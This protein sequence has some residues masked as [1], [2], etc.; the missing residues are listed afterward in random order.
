MREWGFQSG[1]GSGVRTM[2][3]FWSGTRPRNHRNAI[4]T[5]KLDRTPLSASGCCSTPLHY[6][7]AGQFFFPPSSPNPR[8]AFVQLTSHNLSRH[9]PPSASASY[10]IPHPTALKSVFSFISRLG[11][12]RIPS[13]FFSL[14]SLFFLLAS[15]LLAWL[16]FGRTHIHTPWA[17][18]SFFPSR[19]RLE[20][21]CSGVGW[22]MWGRVRRGGWGLVEQGR[23]MGEAGGRGAHVRNWLDWQECRTKGG[24][25]WIGKHLYCL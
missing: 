4:P 2:T 15:C 16:G 22:A 12:C 21:L 19:A 3:R 13:V 6:T 7:R 5:S 25:L 9:L 23:G 11:S 20:G 17:E 10:A 1:D 14:F 24:F 8:L 18:S